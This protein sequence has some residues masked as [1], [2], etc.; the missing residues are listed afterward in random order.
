[1]DRTYEWQRQ[2][3]AAILETDRSRL[4]ELIRAAQAKIEARIAE[5]RSDHNT[6]PEEEQA[7]ADA[8]AGLNILRKETC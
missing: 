1:M 5:L 7:I 4:P 6:S 2:Y 8:V 3:E